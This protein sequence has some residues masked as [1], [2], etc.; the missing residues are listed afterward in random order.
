MNRWWLFVASAAVLCGVFLI[1]S[2]GGGNDDADDDDDNEFEQFGQNDSDSNDQ[3]P[4][5]DGDSACCKTG[6]PCNL[7]NNRKCDCHGLCEWDERECQSTMNFCPGY[8]DGDPCC[9]VSNPCGWNDDGVC[10]CGGYCDWDYND[11]Q[12]PGADD[13]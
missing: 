13:C 9:Q 2:C 7:A 5:Y 6:D 3:C 1:F 12:N 10:D 4:N 8:H 11:C